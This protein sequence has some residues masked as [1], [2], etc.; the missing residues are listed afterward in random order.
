MSVILPLIHSTF[1]TVGVIEMRRVSYRAEDNIREWRTSTPRIGARVMVDPTAV[2]LGDISLG[3]D[4][5]IWGNCSIRADMHRISIG[6]GSN[7]QDNSVL[8]ITHAGRF[9]PEGCP[10]IIGESVT[11]GHRAV[12]HGCAIGDRVLVGMGAVVMDGAVVA[13]EVMVAAGA[14]VTPGKILESGWLYGGS[15]AKAMR[16]ITASERDFLSY[17]AANYVRLKQQ[18]L[19]DTSG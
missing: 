11:V 8:H 13:N 16:K 1:R 6:N 10:L 19:D 2:V 7:I 17:S 18:Y 15:P 14:L 9:N 5:S 12:L 4:V 3:D